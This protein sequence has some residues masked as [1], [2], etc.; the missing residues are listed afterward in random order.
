MY[1]LYQAEIQLPVHLASIAS[2]QAFFNAV[3]RGLSIDEATRQA[4]ELALEE[5]MLGL[6]SYVEDTEELTAIKVN[7]SFNYDSIVITGRAPGRPFD[8]RKLCVR[9]GPLASLD[10]DAT[11]LSGYMIRRLMDSVR[12]SYVE[13]EGQ[14]LSM[15]KKLPSPIQPAFELR[16]AGQG[17]PEQPP[18]GEITCRKASGYEDALAISMCAY[19]IYRYAYKDV[20]YYPQE[21]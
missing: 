9:S 15:L 1:T 13:K 6:F 5:A 20:I 12:W 19:D 3:S 4:V 17:S 18:K 2:L 21:L 14:E 10:D 8:S 16:Y 11:G 7:F